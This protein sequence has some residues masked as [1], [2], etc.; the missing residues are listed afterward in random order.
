[1]TQWKRAHDTFYEYSQANT[2]VYQTAS[3]GRIHTQ[4]TWFVAWD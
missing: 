4:M 2:L 3:I 1:M